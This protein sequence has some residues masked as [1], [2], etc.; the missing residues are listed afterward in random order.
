MNLFCVKNL[1]E[2][3]EGYSSTFDTF[4]ERTNRNHSAIKSLNE[5]AVFEAVLTTKFKEINSTYKEYLARVKDFRRKVLNYKR[6]KKYECFRKE[7]WLE[8]FKQR[9]QRSKAFLTVNGRDEPPFL[10]Q[11]LS[12][13]RR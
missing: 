6:A 11:T 3:K 13:T 2:C 5:F 1:S 8:E 12:L 9:S 4:F 10:N 7:I